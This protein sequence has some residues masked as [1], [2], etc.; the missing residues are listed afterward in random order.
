MKNYCLIINIVGIFY[1][2]ISNQL[3]LGIAL[4]ARYDYTQV[5][6]DKKTEGSVACYV[7][8]ALYTIYPIIIIILY[9]RKN[10]GNCCRK[11]KIDT[12]EIPLVDRNDRYE[13]EIT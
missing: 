5:S 6:D 12:V 10:K 11:K 3:G 4:S 13:I 8:S 1:L 9:I 2:V 7:A